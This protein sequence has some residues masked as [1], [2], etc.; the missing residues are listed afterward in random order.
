MFRRFAYVG[1]LLLAPLCCSAAVVWD[2]STDGDAG[3]GFGTP[4]DL[5]VLGAG[6]WEIIGDLDGGAADSDPGAGPDELDWFRFTTSGPWTIDLTVLTL[7]SAAYWNSSLFDDTPTG[8]GLTASAVPLTDIYGMQPAGTYYVSSIPG[9][10]TGALDYE[11]RINV[12]VPAPLSS[13]LLLS[14]LVAVGST[15]RIVGKDRLRAAS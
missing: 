10:N 2:E 7:T 1:A 15:R 11:L 12:A 3:D 13:V 8:L 4:T 14:G 5:G 6:S 9:M